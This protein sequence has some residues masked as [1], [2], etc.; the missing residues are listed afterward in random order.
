MI[1]RARVVL[2]MN[3]PP[4]E[5][6]AA[7]IEDARIVDVGPFAEIRARR[8]GEVLDLGESILL[9]G[10]INAHCHLDYTMLRG[11]ISPQATFTDWIREINAAKAGLKERDYVKAITAGAA[12]ARRFGT[13][14]LVNLA[15]FPT[16]VSRLPS[17]PLRLWWCAELID[18]RA[19][20]DLRS[21]VA[22]MREMR[23]GSVQ[24]GLAPHAPFTASAQLY[25][26]SARLADAEDLLLTTHLAESHEE[27]EM[28][29]EGSGPLFDFLKQIGRTTQ[30]CGNTTPLQLFLQSVDAIGDRALPRWIVAHLNELSEEDFAMLA[31]RPKFQV[32]HCPRSH[33]YFRHAP[34]QLGRLGELGFNICL[35][36]DSLAS[37]PDLNLLGEMQAFEAQ[38]PG[39]SPRSLLEMVTLNPARA[40]G[41][42]HDLGRIATGFLA[43]LVA[44]A[45]AGGRDP[46]NEVVHFAKPVA[47]M[48]IAGRVLDEV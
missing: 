3:G 6:G 37:N 14:S 21:L 43:D 10:L 34:F 33:R 32:A 42:E 5:N 11:R 15:A 19:K 45:S 29:R 48:M 8:S 26:R 18:L 16:L 41:R 28:F 9:P 22:A 12:E 17:L 36:T 30:D 31:E 20:V 23:L 47:W 24:L 25:A 46:C 40:L 4:I 7:A 35:G 38:E 13:T 2:T 44:I 39:L 27:M 1:L